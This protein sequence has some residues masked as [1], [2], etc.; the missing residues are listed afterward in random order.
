MNKMKFIITLVFSL[1][2]SGTSFAEMKDI[3][4]EKSSVKWLG[5]KVLGKHYGTVK[6]KSGKIDLEGENLKG[7][8]FVMDMTSI[9]CEDLEGEWK[10]KLENHLKDKDFFDTKNHP[11]STF[12]VKVAQSKGKDAWEVTGDLTIKGTKAP[13]TFV[14]K[15]SDKNT[16]DADIV[17]DRTKYNVK[18]NSSRFFENLG[19]KVI[20]DE[21]KMTV[22]L[23]L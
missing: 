2:L 22:S 10:T 11:E 18:Y 12:V 1:F 9:N 20:K 7:G 15:K 21:V 13:V 5:E 4:L 3:N 19:E 8:E 17:F 16:L 23:A 6:L 14:A